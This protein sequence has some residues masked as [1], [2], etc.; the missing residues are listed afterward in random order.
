MK[1]WHKPLAGVARMRASNT[2]DTRLSKQTKHRPS[3]TR[4]KEMF[5]IFDRMLDGL[6]I[7]SN[8]T[9]YDQTRSNSTKQGVQTVKCLVDYEQSPFFLSPSRTEQ[10][11]RECKRAWLKARDGT[12]RNGTDFF[13]SG[14][15]PRFS[16]LAASP[17][18]ARTVEEELKKRGTARSV[19]V[20]SPNNVW[21]CLVAKHL[22]FV[23][24]L[25]FTSKLKCNLIQFYTRH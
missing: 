16:R 19:N 18:D 11:A 6:Q 21:W 17:Q 5:Y 23:Q 3:N 22:S 25:R 9:K 14:C 1:N 8:P 12:G 20:W 15:R 7:L 13:F 4:T 10:N 24:A 2:F